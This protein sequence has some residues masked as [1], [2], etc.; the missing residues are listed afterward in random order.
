MGK[1]GKLKSTNVKL[2]TVYLSMDE[3]EAIKVRAKSLKLSISKY[4][5]LVTR[6]ERHNPSRFGLEVH[7][8]RLHNT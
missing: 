8:G 1:P 3:Y 2:T 7:N 5:V 6:I 4:F